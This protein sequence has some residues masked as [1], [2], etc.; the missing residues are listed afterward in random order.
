MSKHPL[1]SALVTSNLF[2]PRKAEANKHPDKEKVKDGLITVDEGIELGY[3]LYLHHSSAPILLYFHGNGEIV[4]DYEGFAP[5]YH[6]VGVSLLVVDYRGY[7][8]STGKPLTTKMLPD[9][10]AVLDTLDDILKKHS[11]VP[12]RPLFIMG[13]SL[14]SAPALYLTMENPD[15]IKGLII[16]SGFADGPSLFGRLG[17]LIPKALKENETLPINNVHKMKQIKTPLLVIHGERDTLIPV[18]HGKELY[19]A[20]PIEDKELL[21]IKGAGHNNV[22]VVQMDKYF[23][24]IKRFVEG[25]LV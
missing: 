12:S 1:D 18:N 21:I 14:G 15:K 13:R 20:C 4:T 10:Q 5:L 3:R 24:V 19:E 2:F 25:H 16:E 17:I 22:A 7:G 9:A 23:A 6:E 8:W 11:V